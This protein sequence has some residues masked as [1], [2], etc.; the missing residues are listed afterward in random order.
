MTESLHRSGGFKGGGGGAPL[1]VQI[2]SPNS[3]FFHVK[4]L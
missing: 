1:L 3:T 2:F 4:G